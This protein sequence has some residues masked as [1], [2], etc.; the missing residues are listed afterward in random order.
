MPRL[1]TFQLKVHTGARGVNEPPKY[2]ING[3]PL[4][5]DACTGSAQPGE[6]LELRGEPRSFP[7]SLL[8]QG[9]REGTWEIAGLEATYQCAN[10]TPYT[11]RLGPVAL[12]NRSDLNLWYP[13]PAKVIDV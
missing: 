11:V 8:L 13:R 2:T 12:D 6:T 5:F 9:P 3:F 4:D 10:E 7:H 1:D